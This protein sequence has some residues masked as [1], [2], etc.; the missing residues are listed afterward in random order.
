MNRAWLTVT[1]TLLIGG[2]VVTATDGR[3]TLS[4]LAFTAGRGLLSPTEGADLADDLAS[5]LVETGR[6]RVLPREW[7]APEALSEP[8]ALRAAARQAGVRY[9][10]SATVTPLND[11]PSPAPI[12]LAGAARAILAARSRRAPLPCSPARARQSFA[13]IETRVIDGDTGAVVRTSVLRVR[14][15]AAVAIPACGGGATAPVAALIGSRSRPELDSLKS[16]NKE[17]ADSLTLPDHPANQ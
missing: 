5:R 10:V 1:A 8:A 16:A 12:A 4:V 2:S 7:L 3:P 6:F 14:L 11:R 13:L 17:I 9:L 15:S